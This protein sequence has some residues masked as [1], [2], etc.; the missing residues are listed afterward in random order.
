MILGITF[1]EKILQKISIENYLA[2][3]HEYHIDFLEFAPNFIDYDLEFYES[4]N[5]KLKAYNFSINFH[6]PNFVDENLDVSNFNKKNSKEF[7]LYFEKLN[8]AFCLKNLSSTIVFHGAKYGEISK[9]RAITKTLSFINFMLEYFERKNYD[10]SLSIETLNKNNEKIIGDSREDLLEIIDTIHHDQLKICWD[11]THDYLNTDKID[12]PK[13]FFLDSINHCHVHGFVNNNT[14][15]SISKSPILFSTIKF[16]KKNNIP[17]NIEL[18][19]QD[20]YLDILKNDITEIR[21]I[22][23]N[24]DNC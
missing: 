12:L 14:H 4:I 1:E 11:I 24:K 19:M 13:R 17:I 10:L 21:R 5:E 3:L 23:Q 7:I 9:D 15:L 20:K 22:N 16:A 6:L 18:L 8:E 2:L